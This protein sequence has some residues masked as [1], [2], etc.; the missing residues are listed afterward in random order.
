MN[1][2]EAET[3]PVG[4]DL[5][6]VLRGHDDVVLRLTWAPDGK[7]L[8]STSVDRTIRLWDSKTGKLEKVLSGH[9]EGVNEVAWGPDQKWLASASFDRSIRIWDLA[10]AQTVKQ[11]HGHDD[12]VSSIAL[13]TDGRMLASASADRTIRLWRTDTWEQ[14][15]L[16]QEHRSNV[17]RVAWSPDGGRLA[18][19]SKDRSVLV[20]DTDKFR[21]AKK[22]V[23][24]SKPGC[25]A[26]SHNG[27]LLAASM[28]DGTIGVEGPGMRVLEGHTDVVRSAVFSYN[29]RLLASSSMDGTVRLWRTDT[30]EQVAQI[31]EPASGYWPQGIA[32][33][34][35]EPI[36][37]S[38]GERDRV[39]RIWHL[40]IDRLL[41]LEAPV[42]QV[43]YRNAKVVLLGDTGVG[44]TGLRLVLTGE[45]FDKDM[46]LP[47]TFGRRVFAFESREVQA[48]GLKETRE[49]LLW[50]MAGQPAYRLV[51]QLHLSEVVEALVV[52]DARQAVGDP[53]AGVRHWARALRQARQ[54]E[55]GT[56]A[57]L[58]AFLVWG[59][60]DVQGT[61]ISRERIDAVKREWGFEQFFETSAAEGRGM[62][63]LAAAMR[64]AIAWDA[65][66]VV[67]SP[68]LFEKLKTFLCRREGNRPR[69][70]AGGRF[71]PLLSGGEPRRE[72]G[73]ETARHL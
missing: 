49:T 52:F 7:T 60:A 2:S 30:W 58:K 17:Y 70:R 63:E 73:P 1:A 10:L 65:L 69:H 13:S 25:V 3:R 14:T 51:H 19:C 35:T 44:K 39:I 46:R 36:L 21:V 28:F 40:D 20:W 33:H 18:S 24:K 72:Q 5:L 37:A 43:N 50:D 26:W 47:S 12:D 9:H 34:P 29:D 53:L 31:D 22:K 41:G 8:A 67:S 64:D 15:G 62:K 4:F 42:E 66:P 68:K 45:P 11:L 54:R 6:Q 55:V 27:V 23:F 59:R 48:D 32:F 56:I 16:L 38:F 61:T 57:P 71:V